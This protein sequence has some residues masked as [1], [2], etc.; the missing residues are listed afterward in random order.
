[1][2]LRVRAVGPDFSAP[3]RN[4]TTHCR[5][6]LCGGFQADCQS[7]RQDSNLHCHGL[8]GPLPLPWATDAVPATP[9][10]SNPHSPSRGVLP[11][12]S[13]VAVPEHYPA[14][15]SEST[16]NPAQKRKQG[17]DPKAN[18]LQPHPVLDQEIVGVGELRSATRR[19]QSTSTIG[20]CVPSVWHTIEMA[21]STSVGSVEG[22]LSP[23]CSSST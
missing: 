19:T 9:W 14:P 17:A 16:Q 5:S 23:T 20:S 4:G 7:A 1:M 13:G 21:M 12:R 15:V 11:V 22:V 6:S 10:D 18:P 3:V 8:C 2:R